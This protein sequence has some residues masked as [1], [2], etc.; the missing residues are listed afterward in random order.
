MPQVRQGRNV[1]SDLPITAELISKQRLE[2]LTAFF[3]LVA[4]FIDGQE[5]WD[6]IKPSKGILGPWGIKGHLH[7][8]D[9]RSPITLMERPC[10]KG[11]IL[12]LN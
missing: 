5:T 7:K 1:S 4:L 12:G 2:K 9:A 8:P 11:E 10:A 6:P 3:S